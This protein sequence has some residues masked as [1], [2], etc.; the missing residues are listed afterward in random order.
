VNELRTDCD[1]FS[2]ELF[3]RHLAEISKI[4]FLKLFTTVILKAEHETEKNSTVKLTKRILY[5]PLQAKA[6]TV[7]FPQQRH[8]HIIII[9]TTCNFFN[10]FILMP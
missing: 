5:F 4:I 2:L 10:L 7:Q 8:R 9:I 6:R 3:Q 1:A